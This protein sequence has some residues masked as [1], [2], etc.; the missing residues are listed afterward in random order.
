MFDD[1][2][3]IDGPI[4]LESITKQVTEDPL[5][6]ADT[7]RK[8]F[9][10]QDQGHQRL[11]RGTLVTGYVVTQQLLAT[12]RLLD[13][14]YER[15]FPKSNKKPKEPRKVLLRVLRH[16]L[17]AK[18]TKGPAYDRAWTYSKGLTP[19][20][21]RQATPMEVSDELE[22]V[23]I[24]GLY[25]KAIHKEQISP[26][27]S[28]DDPD[29]NQND[30]PEKIVASAAQRKTA[31]SKS[32]SL[33]DVEDDIEGMEEHR[34]RASSG[35]KRPPL[36]DGKENEPKKPI[37]EVELEPELL[38]EI[39]DKPVGYEGL[40][41]IKITGAEA[42]GWVCVAGLKLKKPKRPL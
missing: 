35:G 5:K 37:L 17:G 20:L 28:G 42:G 6:A 15:Y 11:L 16:V 9:A 36:P 39:L 31:F 41:V 26:A 23:G 25:R 30:L 33:L 22:V 2:N 29:A 19:L 12:S 7:C 1:E 10:A 4:D 27:Q 24:E 13:K 40:L 32:T 14:F 21:E 18:I 8:A 34:G 38:A 3:E